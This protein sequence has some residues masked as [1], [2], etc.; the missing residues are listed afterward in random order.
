MNIIQNAM[1]KGLKQINLPNQRWKDVQK[2]KPSKVFLFGGIKGIEYFL[3]KYGTHYSVEYILDNDIS[4]E[5]KLFGQYSE[6]FP[7]SMLEYASPSILKAYNKTELIV[8]VTS[9]NYYDEIV[10]QLIDLG[11]INIFVLCLMESA[12]VGVKLQHYFYVIRNKIY[13][14]IKYIRRKVIFQYCKYYGL[15]E[16]ILNVRKEFRKIWKNAPIINDKVIFSSYDGRDYSGHNKYITEELIR[17]GY[18]GDIVWILKC[19]NDEVPKEIRIISPDNL[20]EIIY[21]MATAKVWL[22][23]VIQKKYVIKRKGQYYIQVKHWSSITLKKFYLDTI[24][25]LHGKS[26]IAAYKHDA[27][28]IDYVVVGSDFD[29]QTFKSGMRLTDNKKFLMFGSP[30]SDALFSK[31]LYCK[32]IHNEFDIPNDANI[33]LYAPTFRINT[34]EGKNDFSILKQMLNFENLLSTL[35]S[36]YNKEWYVLLRLH[37]NVREFSRDI[38]LPQNVIN[39]SF[40]CDSQELVSGC[41]MLISDYSSIMFEAAYV[42]KPVFLYIP[43]LNDYIQKERGVWINIS[44]LPFLVAKSDVELQNLIYNFDQCIYEKTVKYFLDKY[45]VHEDGLASKR[46]VDFIIHNLILNDNKIC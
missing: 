6:K 40:Y 14:P 17:E 33:V 36:R 7:D 12:K 23:D 8:I 20:K 41:D 35:K 11:I 42:L 18:E 9:T 21:E 34:E 46:V 38:V 29:A 31:N 3:K 10:E 13:S 16:G 19:R 1:L 37:P 4:K 24:N 15:T 30:R 25:I 22:S 26:S 45:G 32:K 39:A 2:L 44:E 28:L 27:K 5:N 43:D